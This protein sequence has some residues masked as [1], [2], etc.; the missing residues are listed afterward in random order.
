ML[1]NLSVPIQMPLDTSLR[2]GII[3]KL[4]DNI[5]D[6][7]G[8]IHIMVKIGWSPRRVIE[9]LQYLDYDLIPN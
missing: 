2:R 1:E 5:S 8:D 9:N 4:R 7:N 6:F 3:I